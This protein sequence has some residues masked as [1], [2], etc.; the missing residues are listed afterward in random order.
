MVLT[1]IST[2]AIKLIIDIIIMVYG[3]GLRF[4]M[5]ILGRVPNIRPVLEYF[6][7]TENEFNEFMVIQKKVTK[8]LSDRSLVEKESAGSMKFS[9]SG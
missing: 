2:E 6:H 1:L 9:A 8:F 4:G 7:M 3:L 5:K